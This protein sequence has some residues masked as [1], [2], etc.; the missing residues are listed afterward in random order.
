MPGEDHS[1]VISECLRSWPNF[2]GLHISPRQLVAPYAGQIPN[3]F[4]S[5]RMA[6]PQHSLP[7]VTYTRMEVWSFKFVYVIIN[8]VCV[9]I[10]G[11]QVLSGRVPYYYLK[12][13]GRIL[14]ELHNGIQPRQPDQPWITETHWHFIQQCWTSPDGTERPKIADIVQFVEEQYQ[15]SCELQEGLVTQELQFVESILPWFSC[16]IW[17]DPNYIISQINFKSTYYE[18]MLLTGTEVCWT[19]P[20]NH[21]SF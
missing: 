16:K 8:H 9:L 21:P 6:L 19:S 3:S 7:L 1:C 2:K 13:D 11:I 14:M 4:V 18:N 15:T 12:L 5:V 20:A 17:V 10:P